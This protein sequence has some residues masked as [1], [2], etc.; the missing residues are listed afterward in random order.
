MGCPLV[1]RDSEWITLRT[2]GQ[3]YTN[4]ISVDLA[5]RAKVSK[6]GI[7]VILRET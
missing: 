7:T 6:G 4:Y 3:S 5:H 1:R 2:G